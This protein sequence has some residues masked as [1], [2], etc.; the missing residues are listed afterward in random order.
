LHNQC[1]SDALFQKFLKV[2]SKNRFSATY[3]SSSTYL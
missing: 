3:S 2:S 1:P